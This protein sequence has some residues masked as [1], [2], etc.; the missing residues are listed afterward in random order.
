MKNLSLTQF[1][2]TLFLIFFL[3]INCISCK[4]DDTTVSCLPDEN[5]SAQ[6]NL[7]LP[8]YST[9][10][11]PNG[12]YVFPSDGTNGS[13]G[14]IVVNT[15]TGFIAYDR[16]APHICPS[17]NSTLVVEDGIKLVCPEDQAEWVLR[18]GQPVNDQTN[19]RTPRR[20]LANVEGS[21]LTITY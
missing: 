20:F 10:T 17:A 2:K 16:N 4:D 11:I 8:A 1:Y 19:G 12:Y 21:L 3:S 14:V 18:S 7:N 9:L 5:V 15:G 6:Y 13:R